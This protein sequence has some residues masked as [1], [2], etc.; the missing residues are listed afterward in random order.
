MY[1]TATF[2][3][4]LFSGAIEIKTKPKK[5]VKKDQIKLKSFCTAMK[6]TNKMKRQLTE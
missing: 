3:V 1:I 4:N 2:F 6:I 5:K